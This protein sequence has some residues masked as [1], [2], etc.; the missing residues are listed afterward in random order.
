MDRSTKFI[1]TRR[2][3]DQWQLLLNQYDPQIMTVDEFC[4]QQKIS[5]S[6]FYMWRKKLMPDIEENNSIPLF[7]KIPQSI[8]SPSPTTVPWDVELEIGGSIVLRI[9]KSC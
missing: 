1:K 3:Q 2:S 4:Q 9:R 6:T 5:Q 8:S 7:V